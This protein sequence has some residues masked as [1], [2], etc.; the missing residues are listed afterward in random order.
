MTKRANPWP[1]LQMSRGMRCSCLYRFYDQ[2]RSSTIWICSPRTVGHLS[3]ALLRNL[4]AL[5]DL[6]G[7]WYVWSRSCVCAQPE[8]P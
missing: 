3:G 1:P 8:A 2:V 5:V 6:Q 7:D 4:E